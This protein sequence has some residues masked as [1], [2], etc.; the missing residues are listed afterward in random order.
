MPL[1]AQNAT[2]KNLKDPVAYHFVLG[3]QKLLS[4]DTRL[5]LEFYNK[6]Y[7]H[8]PLDPVQPQLFIIDQVVQT[9][10]FYNSNPLADNGKALLAIPLVRRRGKAVAVVL[11]LPHP[12]VLSF[13]GR[14]T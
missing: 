7:D 6:E 13:P 4:E 9:S 8:F 11:P 14:L 12:K 1:L 2:S 5:T 3:F 10:V